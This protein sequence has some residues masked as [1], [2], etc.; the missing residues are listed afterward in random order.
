[1]TSTTSAITDATLSDESAPCHGYFLI[2][3][4]VVPTR[5]GP[6]T[7]TRLDHEL[8]SRLWVEAGDAFQGV[9]PSTSGRTPAATTDVPA[10]LGTHV[11]LDQ[12]VTSST[13]DNIDRELL[14][15]SEL[16][17]RFALFVFKAENERFEDGMG[18]EFATRVNESIVSYGPIAVAAWERVLWR[19]ENANETGEELL[20]QLGLIEH[21]PSRARRLRVLKDSLKSHDSRIRDAAGLG[22]SFLDDT[23]AL[24]ALQSAYRRETEG[25][26]KE[27]LKLV[28]DQ[29]MDN[30][31]AEIPQSGTSGSLV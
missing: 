13:A 3:S 15:E 24:I 29:L 1:M 19:M 2:G 8:S 31:N 26:L 18:S 6:S 16:A 21:L 28:I 27:N 4:T 9:P 12:P 10:R 5:W 17:I 30:D 11:S 14:C 20:R 25:W 7:S 22:L 23:S